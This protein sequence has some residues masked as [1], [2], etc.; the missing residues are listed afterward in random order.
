MFKIESFLSARL[1]LAPE[2]V[3]DKIFFL[4]NMSGRLSLYSMGKKGSVPVPLLPPEIAVQNPHLVGNLYRV[5][6][7][8]KKI[9]IM[10]DKDG[11][12]NYQPM[13]IPIC[14][15]YPDPIISDFF[16]DTSSN[17]RFYLVKTFPDKNL[18]YF[19]AASH[20]KPLHITFRLNL[21]TGEMIKYHESIHGADIDGVNTEHNKFI[22]NEGY[23]V[24]DQVLYLW[25]NGESM[26]LYGTPLGDRE[27]GKTYPLNSIYGCHFVNKDRGILF[28]TAMFDDRGGLGYLD[29]QNP[30][31]VH[32]IKIT[33]IKHHGKGEFN[34]IRHMKKDRYFAFYNIDGSSWVYEGTFTR[35]D[36]V[37]KLT[38]V[39][40]GKGKVS[41]GV[42]EHLSWEKETDNISLS[43]STAISP[44][45]IYRIKKNRDKIQQLTDE[46][47][48]AIPEK[49]L[50]RGEDVSFTSFDDLRIS[51][52]LYFPDENLGF[53]NPRPLIYYI[54]GGPQSQERPDFS[55]FSMPLIQ[56]LTLNG[57]A[58][59]VPIP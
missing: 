44:T 16:Q 34:G 32:P 1:F 54:H 59:F 40:V 39:I 53:E 50:S 33:G 23:T 38:N 36:L 24:G 9:L 8:I 6:P 49:I 43:F 58:V 28:F 57:F 20:H 4:S 31:K 19:T 45:Q 47:V 22:L 14:G 51:A 27:P 2:K 11:D 30:K 7:G 10:L 48:L 25:E 29:I 17:Y 12:E 21:K 56:Y 15:G 35:K 26:V 42:L 13:L 3:D 37:F 41:N 55:W 52:R 46:R 5:F 18:A